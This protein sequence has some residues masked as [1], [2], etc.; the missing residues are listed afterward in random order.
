MGSASEGLLEISHLRSW[1][2]FPKRPPAVPTRPSW[3][4]LLHANQ[5]VH[6]ERLKYLHLPKQGL[7]GPLPLA[8]DSA[9]GFGLVVQQ[10]GLLGGL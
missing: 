7:M 9:G 5:C 1:S 2:L 6:H 3:E 8:S 4:A 10:Q